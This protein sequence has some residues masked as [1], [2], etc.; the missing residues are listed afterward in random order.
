MGAGAANAGLTQYMGGDGRDGER[1]RGDEGDRWGGG[2]E[3]GV[4]GHG[5]I[6]PLPFKVRGS[7]GKGGGAR[8]VSLSF[9]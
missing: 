4:G 5:F 1:R 2:W 9:S 7:W 6:L 8:R 3:G